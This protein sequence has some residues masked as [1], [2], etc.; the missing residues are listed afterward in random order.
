MSLLA[1]PRL[2]SRCR[3]GRGAKCGTGGPAMTGGPAGPGR[4]GKPVIFVVDADLPS[5][6]GLRLDV[7]RRFA[8][9]AGPRLQ[10]V[11]VIGQ[12]WARR[13]HQIRDLLSRNGVP[14]GF[15]PPDGHTG[16]EVLRQAGLAGADLPVLRPR[17]LASRYLSRAGP[18]RPGRPPSIWPGPPAKSPWWCG[19][20][21]RLTA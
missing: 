6:R 18:T 5:L 7:R 8:A 4:G 9:A 14:F 12:Q 17:W 16:T 20:P 21:A 15:Y 3:R 2:A 13:S 1:D 11:E 10:V 19:A